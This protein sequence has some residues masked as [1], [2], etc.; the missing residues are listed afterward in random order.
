MTAAQVKGDDEILGK[1]YDAQIVRRLFGYLRP[2]RRRLSLA[3][4]FMIAAT[5][6][7][8][9]GPYFVKIALD[10]GVAPRNPA[11]LGQAVLGYAVAALVLWLGTFVRVR[12]MA[13]T[14]Q[15]V[16]YDLRRQMFDHLQALSLGFFSRYAVGRLVSRMVN[17]VSVLREMIVWA[18]LAVVRNLFDLVGISL[19]MLSLHW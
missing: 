6:A 2:Y 7:N 1:A 3:L 10:G 11:V 8:V 17:D 19:A 9:S 18:M 16:I 13:V 15:N 12:L 5:L 14:G 4:A